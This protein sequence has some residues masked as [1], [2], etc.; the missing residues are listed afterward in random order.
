[1]N[2]CSCGHIRFYSCTR[3]SYVGDAAPSLGP[4]THV[5]FCCSLSRPFFSI[6][7]GETTR[8]NSELLASRCSTVSQIQANH[9]VYSAYAYKSLS[10]SRVFVSALST[11]DIRPLFHRVS[12]IE[13]SYFRS[14][15]ESMSHQSVRLQFFYTPHPNSFLASTS[16]VFLLVFRSLPLVVLSL[17]YDF[18][19]S[20]TSVSFT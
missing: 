12:R 10:L 1:M 11:S 15:S 8:D 7:L 4:S 14:R 17:F 6:F 13:I 19:V 2:T 3:F 18:D 16:L 5:L 20:S 9:R